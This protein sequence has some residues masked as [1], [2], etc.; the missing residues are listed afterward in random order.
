W[1]PLRATN[2]VPGV[3]AR[4]SSARR[5]MRREPASSGIGAARRSAA[6]TGASSA[7]SGAGRTAGSKGKERGAL[8]TLPE[9]EH[10][11]ALGQRAAGLGRLGGHGPAPHQPR[12]DAEGG[13]P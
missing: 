1:S 7:A 8:T 11:G 4:L 3:T 13:E 10:G 9:R 6:C 2:R 5:W 12:I